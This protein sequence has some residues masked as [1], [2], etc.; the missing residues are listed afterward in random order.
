MAAAAALA[1]AQGKF[2][3][4]FVLKQLISSDECPLELASF[5]RNKSKTTLTPLTADEALAFLISS[6]LT[7]SAYQMMRNIAVSH[8]ADIFPSYRKVLKAK[9][10]CYPANIFVTEAKAEV[11]LQDLLNHTTK[12]ILQIDSVKSKIDEVKDL[13]EP[14]FVLSG[15]WGFDGA[16]GQ[17]RY[18]QRF[19]SIENESDQHLFSTMFVPLDLSYENS[20]INSAQQ[21]HSVWRNDRPSSKRFC[22]PLR[23]QYKRETYGVLREEKNY[24]DGQI[25]Q[26]QETIV[27]FDASEDTQTIQLRVKY[28]LKCTMIDGKAANAICGNKSSLTC[29]ICKARPT[30][31]NLILSLNFLIDDNSLDLGISS[32]HMWIR[33]F[34]FILH[35]SYR[36]EFKTWQIRYPHHKILAKNR[37]KRIQQD[38][39]R[40]LGLLVDIPKDGGSGTTNDGNTARK[41]FR[42]FDT[43]AEITGVDVKLILRLYVILCV[44][45]SNEKIDT[46]KF[47]RYCMETYEFYVE[48]YKWFYMPVSMH[49]LLIHGAQVISNFLLPIGGYSEEALETRNRDNLYFREHH[50]RKCHRIKTMADQ[51]NRL[52]ITSDP[53]ISSINQPAKKKGKLEMPNEALELLVLSEEFELEEESIEL[54]YLGGEVGNHDSHR[55]PELKENRDEDLELPYYYFE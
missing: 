9:T 18:K 49:K 40:L 8:Q 44:I 32:L 14:I 4:A 28:D 15:K 22:A 52:L 54:E 42:N 53:Y 33:G 47:E 35:L 7:Q 27:D 3:L 50:A 36:L 20:S 2:S 39:R 41:A 12:R 51:H 38:F 43:F 46:N 25:G 11:P 37:K 1:R 30:E 23:I 45:N 29:N 19:D 24:Y 48:K 34:E 5:L 17:S 10:E 26:L 13:F 16:S 55:L 31:M 6:D 21:Y